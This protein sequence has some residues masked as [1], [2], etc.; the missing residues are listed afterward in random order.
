MQAMAAHL[1]DQMFAGFGSLCVA[2]SEKEEIGQ[3]QIRVLIPFPLIFLADQILQ[4]QLPGHQ[5]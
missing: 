2:R 1:E 5:K 3:S 4:L